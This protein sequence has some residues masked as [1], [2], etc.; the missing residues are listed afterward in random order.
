MSDW[1]P[2]RFWTQSAV[3]EAEGGF[4]VELDGRRVKTPAK[5]GLIVPTQTMAQEIAAEW[6]AQEK[7]V[8]PTTMPFTRSANAAI[9]KVQHQHAEVAD[10]LADYGD[11]DLLCYRATHPQE[12][13]QRQAEQWDP[14]LDW[15]AET[16]AARLV[17]VA[18][19]LHRPQ[20]TSTLQSLRQRVHD[21]NDFQL[22]AFHDLV[23][24]SGS[25]ILGFAVSA[26]WRA[27]EDIWEVSRLDEL[28]QI[29]QW[30]HDDEAHA[31]SEVKRAAFLHA[32]RFFD[33]SV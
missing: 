10:M 29:E 20:D 2:K 3:I 27:V 6:D 7:E 28:W 33:L 23:S 9:D 14:A 1:K 30:G 32:K 8:D 22:A 25:L 16:L 31:A 17:P 26:N 18:G 5:A 19:V 15:A 13:Q 21:F 11:S 12:L 24:L 4:T